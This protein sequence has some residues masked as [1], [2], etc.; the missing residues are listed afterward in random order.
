MFDGD[1]SPIVFSMKEEYRMRSRIA[2]LMVLAL[3]V[4]SV[5]AC[6]HL[7]PATKITSIL[8]NPRDYA[9]RQITVSGTVQDAY[10]TVPDT[11]IC[12]SA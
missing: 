4:L 6:S 8:T 12:L 5:T 10:S 1:L 7:M 11:V 2:L 9:D 3:L